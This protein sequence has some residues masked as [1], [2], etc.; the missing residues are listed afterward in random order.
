MLWNEIKDLVKTKL[1]ITSYQLWIEKL[2]CISDN[3][4]SLELACPDNFSLS[5]ITENYLPIINDSLAE[6]GKGTVA[7]QLRVASSVDDGKGH[8][9]GTPAAEQLYLPNMPPV[10]S[11]VRT[12]HP[13][14][15]FDQFVVGDCNSLAYSVCQAVVSGD[16]S[17]GPCVY[18]EA[19]T[20]LGK[21]HLSHAVSHHLLQYSPGTRLHFLTAEQFTS[22]MVRGIKTNTM[23]QVKEKY[24]NHCDVL[25]LE[26]AHTLVGRE[27]TQIELAQA[28]DVLMEKG[29]VIL[30]TGAMAPW[31][32]T[33]LNEEIRS[34]L[35]AG[36]VTSI[37]PP[38][39]ETRLLIVKR[40]SEN[41]NMALSEDIIGYLAENIRG[42]IRQVESAVAGLRAKS[43]LLNQT[44]DLDMARE[45]VQT[46]V[47]THS[48]GLTV[49][50]IRNFISAQYRISISDLQSKSRKKNV[51]A[52]RQIAMYLARKLTDQGLVDIGKAFDRD[53]STVV[54]SIRVVTELIIRDGSIRGQVELLTRKLQEGKK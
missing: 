46:I 5:W 37:N 49:E 8:G 52:P 19:G 44:P 45:I 9:Q 4:G 27:K 50:A 42:D 3:N 38:E 31:K 24:R 34:R 21:S 39:F 51:S 26:G 30:F 12:L 13:K 43:T 29:K 54:H 36:V 20:G 25:V 17:I 11:W 41:Y 6:V 33:G 10:R 22:E 23:E 28:L 7:V 35:N 1:P 40:K 32:I 16:T 47:G 2:H 18:I 14:Y 15:T 53:H 48:S